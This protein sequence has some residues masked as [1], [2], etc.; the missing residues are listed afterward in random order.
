MLDLS[1]AFSAAK[2]MIVC[3]CECVC[4]YDGLH[5]Y[6]LYIE[7]SLHP[8]DEASLIMVNDVLGIFSY[9]SCIIL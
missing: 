7:P 4:V 1:K 2:G 8:L 9:S 3:V 5:C 6:I